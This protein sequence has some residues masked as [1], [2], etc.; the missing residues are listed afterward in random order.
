MRLKLV[1]VTLLAGLLTACGDAGPSASEIQDAF[2]RKIT[3]D[4]EQARKEYGD[5]LAAALQAPPPEL[6]E[7]V[8]VDNIRSTDSATYVADITLKNTKSGAKNT[9]SLGVR[10]IE[11]QWSVVNA[12][13]SSSSSSSSSGEADVPFEQQQ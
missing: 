5:T 9:N 6:F 7:V 13:S 4:H 11:G 1:I 12:A 10:K 2:T 3:Q 8:A